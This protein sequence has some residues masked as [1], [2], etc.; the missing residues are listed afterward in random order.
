M[1]CV[2]SIAATENTTLK[3][4]RFFDTAD[5]WTN[6]STIIGQNRQSRNS[7]ATFRPGLFAPFARARSSREFRIADY[8]R[9]I[10]TGRIL[11]V[12]P[13][14]YVL[15]LSLSL[16]FFTQLIFQTMQRRSRVTTTVPLLALLSFWI[17]RTELAKCMNCQPHL[18]A[19]KNSNA[20]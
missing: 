13:R 19:G 7:P 5:N 15:S 16:S 20:R 14:S 11:G 3:S 8:R 6:I 9:W 10:R 17:T 12:S 1:P 18:G 4:Q 2:P